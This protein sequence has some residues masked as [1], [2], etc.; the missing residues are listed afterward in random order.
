MAGFSSNGLCI[1]YVT[2]PDLSPG[3]QLDVLTEFV[4]SAPNQA[5]RVA[6]RMPSATDDQ[7][8][9]LLN[10]YLL[11]IE[12]AGVTSLLLPPL[13]HNRPMLVAR[14]PGCGLWLSTQWLA[15][16]HVADAY[17]VHSLDEATDAFDAGARE[18]VFGHVFASESHP[19]KPGRGIAALQHL[20]LMMRM[21]VD[22]PVITAIGG[23]DE[24]SIQAIGAAG[25]R[26]VACIRAVSRSP[27]IASTLR[28]MCEIW[29]VGTT[30]YVQEGHT[31]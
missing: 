19:G 18:L 5:L 7:V 31:R 2:D 23:I 3:R 28:G 4:R 30:T 24:D 13:I 20:K 10:A 6:F 15:E 9:S 11:A 25:I 27:D 21:D 1:T 26:S 12:R 16:I 8:E 14:Y 17:S 22:E 29:H